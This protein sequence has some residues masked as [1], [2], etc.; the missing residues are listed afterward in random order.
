MSSIDL[1]DSVYFHGDT[2]G[3]G[4][5]ANGKASVLSGGLTED[6]DHEVGSAID[7]LGSVSY[8]HLTLPTT[9]AV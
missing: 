9:E 1:K 8:T 5:G 6:C 7:D 3:K 2:E 4:V